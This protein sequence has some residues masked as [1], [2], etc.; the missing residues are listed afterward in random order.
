M[1]LEEPCLCR[2]PLKRLCFLFPTKRKAGRRSVSSCLK[3]TLAKPKNR[4]REMIILF[5]IK[6]S[7]VNTVEVEELF[8]MMNETGITK[9]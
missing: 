7:G 8:K 4:D 6:M 5:P 2:Q 9:K 3:V 1:G